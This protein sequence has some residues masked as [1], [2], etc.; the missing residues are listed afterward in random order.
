MLS[1][2]WFIFNLIGANMDHKTHL[3]FS[4]DRNWILIHQGSPL[5]D[6]KKTYDEVMQVVK[7]YK[8]TLPDVTWNGDRFEW[9]T[10]STI[11]ETGA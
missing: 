7:Y 4:N 11:V 9:V 10:T 5:C 8:I 3:S 6:Y 2:H 1:Y